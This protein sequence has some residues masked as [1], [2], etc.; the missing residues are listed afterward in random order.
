MQWRSE[1]GRL[2]VTFADGGLARVDTAVG[3]VI[4]T[5]ADDGSNAFA[6]TQRMPAL[7]PAVDSSYQFAENLR[8]A[9]IGATVD[10]SVQFAEA[11]RMIAAGTA[12]GTADDSHEFAE[13]QRMWA[14]ADTSWQE[15]EGRGFATLDP[16]GK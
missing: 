3:I 9:A 15:A 16:N 1:S 6:E 7:A 8:F 2:A 12:G 13:F 4:T 5:N 14:L 10:S 11:Q